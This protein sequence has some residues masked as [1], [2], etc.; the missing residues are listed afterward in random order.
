MGGLPA[1]PADRERHQDHGTG[2]IRR[3]LFHRHRVECRQRHPDRRHRHRD[4]RRRRAVQTRGPHT[5]TTSLKDLRTF[6]CPPPG[7]LSTTRRAIGRP[8][9]LS[10]MEPAFLARFSRNRPATMPRRSAARCSSRRCFA[11]FCTRLADRAHTLEAAECV[12]T[13]WLGVTRAMPDRREPAGHG[14]ALANWCRG[15]TRARSTNVTDANSRRNAAARRRRP[16]AA[17]PS[18]LQRHRR[19]PRKPTSRQAFCQ[20]RTR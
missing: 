16:P 6:S 17:P 4:D 1:V 2:R 9:R 19:R 12:G 20:N 14:F 5:R 18:S 7:R 10:E 15:V 8:D 13:G 3:Q 11:D